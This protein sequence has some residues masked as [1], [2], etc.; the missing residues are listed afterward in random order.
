MPIRYMNASFTL[1]GKPDSISQENWEKRWE[2]TFGKGAKPPTAAEPAGAP[3]VKSA[4]LEIV[5][6]AKSCVGDRVERIA[7]I[8]QTLH[9]AI[10]D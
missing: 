8:A 9:D 4:L 3:F 5:V 1:G 2:Q 6:L 10:T 7:F